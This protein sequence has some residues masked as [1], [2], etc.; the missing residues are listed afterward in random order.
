MGLK[1]L[2]FLALFSMFQMR[3]DFYTELVEN[4]KY[5]MELIFIGLII[6]LV[7]F[8]LKGSSQNLAVLRNFLNKTIHV[9]KDNFYHVGLRLDEFENY[10]GDIDAIIE[11][12]E[13][14][15]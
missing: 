11:N 8:Y 5:N 10:A 4:K 15:E 2:I 13:I 14:L 3:E 1:F 12:E 6:V 9:F 7:Y